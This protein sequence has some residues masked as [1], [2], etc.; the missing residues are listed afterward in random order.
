MTT[1]STLL[2]RIRTWLRS[3]MK[4]LRWVF[5]T[6]YIALIA[7][8]STPFFG[9]N[10]G[11][12]W[13]WTSLAG[14]ML[15]SQALFIFGS[16]TIQLCHPIRKRNL[17]MPV[18]TAASMLTVLFV[19]LSLAL[20]EL[21]DQTLN[22]IITPQNDE[23]V[24]IGFG[25]LMACNWLFWGVLLWVYAKRWPRI[26]TMS[27]LATL[28]FAGS[29]AELLAAVPS[30]II[31]SKRPGCIVGV[32]TMLGICAG[33]YVML[34][35]FGPGIA[36]LFLRPRYRREQ[37]EASPVCMECSYDLRGSLAAGSTTCPE[38]GSTIPEAVL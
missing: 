32:F 16:G 28:I 30:H 2:R 22:K 31:V 5:L 4:I 18:L 21:F 3:D 20:A 11:G 6:L 8:L 17:W 33:I 37:M 10:G 34:F 24:F 35:S 19:G 12:G 13:A 38:C 14:I 7:G 9:G 1:T 25:V 36:L 26:K 15:G 27:R 23:Y 29:L